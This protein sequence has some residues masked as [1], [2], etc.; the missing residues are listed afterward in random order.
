MMYAW[1]CNKVSSPVTS[2]LG[3]KPVEGAHDPMDTCNPMDDLLMLESLE[4]P[5]CML[6]DAQH[7]CCTSTQ[8]Y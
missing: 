7:R 4:S 5:R 6:L 2:D 3:H 8:Q 1:E